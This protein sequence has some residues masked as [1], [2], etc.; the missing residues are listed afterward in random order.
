MYAKVEK[1]K[2][3]KS[4][5]VANSVTQK[6]S[7]DQQVY[8][9]LDN[10]LVLQ[11]VK[12]IG[13]IVRSEQR[14]TPQ[15]ALLKYLDYLI[16]LAFAFQEAPYIPVALA[17]IRDRISSEESLTSSTIKNYRDEIKVYTDQLQDLEDAIPEP[18]DS[19]ITLKYQPLKACVIQSL[20]QYGVLGM[21]AREYHADLWKNNNKLK[22]YDL[23]QNITPIYSGFNL[24]EKKYGGKYSDLI[25][26]LA[27][28]KYIF[29]VDSPAGPNGHMFY[30]EI[31]ANS[32]KNKPNFAIPK[33]DSENTQ[34][35]A[36]GDKI[37]RFWE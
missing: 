34:Y 19:D 21:T 29:N 6:K 37:L 28:G 3:N 22:Y 36:D 1:P 35:W 14:I 23:D 12:S 18:L 33:Q 4:R 24:S 9:F 20:E 16:S 30:L 32:K 2:E 10:R 13:E 27:V 5:A 15:Q 26:T 31:R 25:R 11:R 17:K 7:D 8:N